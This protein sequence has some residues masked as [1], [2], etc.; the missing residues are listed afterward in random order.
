MVNYFEAMV[1]LKEGE[2]IVSLVTGRILR[3]EEVGVVWAGEHYCAI[4]VQILR[5][6]TLG[7]WQV[8][9]EPLSDMEIMEMRLGE[10]L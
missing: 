6:E 4:N 3:P 1:A 5:V 10:C 7:N 8:Y 2:A 9:I